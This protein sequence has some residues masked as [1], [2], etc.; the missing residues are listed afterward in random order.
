MH[1]IVLR[2]KTETEPQVAIFSHPEMRRKDRMRIR[3]QRVVR[4]EDRPLSQ[5]KASL[6]SPVS[7]H[8]SA[9]TADQMNSETTSKILE[10]KS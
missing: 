8:E 1:Q 9:K 5:R 10:P 2:G 4:R 6:F 3:D 7:S